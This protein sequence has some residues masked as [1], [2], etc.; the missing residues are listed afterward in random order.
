[1]NWFASK[2]PAGTFSETFIAVN[3]LLLIFVFFV[4]R[5]VWGIYAIGLLIIDF[6]AIRD[7]VHPFFPIVVIVLNMSLNVL[8]IYWFSKMINIAIKKIYPDKTKE[9]KEQ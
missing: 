8:N 7:K 5:I 6:Y 9:K 3:G 1:M 4:V 2:L